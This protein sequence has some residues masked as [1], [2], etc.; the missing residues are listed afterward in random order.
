MPKTPKDFSRGLIYKLCCNDTNVKEIYVGSTTN[1]TKRKDCHKS[2]CNNINSKNYNCYV[3][4]FIRE[5]GGWENW[6]MI[7]VEKYPC[8]DVLELKQRERHWIEE[9]KA[10]LNKVIPTRTP[11]EWREANTVKYKRYQKEY[12]KEY[13]K[14]YYK[15][16]HERIKR[17]KKMNYIQRTYETIINEIFYGGED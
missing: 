3:Y 8:N 9:L 10:E 17:R 4:Q 1:F 7:M 16:N 2:D 12:H 14:T 11:K 13:Q 6:S 15:A 5:N